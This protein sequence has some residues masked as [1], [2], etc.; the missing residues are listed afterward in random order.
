MDLI[1]TAD[2]ADRARGHLHCNGND[3]ACALGRG[4]VGIEKQ[5][6]DGKTPAGR[7]PLRSILYRADRLNPPETGLPAKPMTETD[8]WCDD[9]D[10][11]QY[12]KPVTHPYPSS[13]EHLWREDSL[14][15]VIVVL[16]HNDDPV[17]PGRGSAV[18]LHVA[19][20]DYAPTQ[21]CVA[22]QRDHLIEVLAKCTEPTWIEINPPQP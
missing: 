16:G 7:F 3:Y 5:E 1:V 12:N 4:G 18:F 14:Y 22:L 20:D 21:G 9:P 17:V 15:D 8:G 6:G 13:A 10:D 19:S 11:R 2:D